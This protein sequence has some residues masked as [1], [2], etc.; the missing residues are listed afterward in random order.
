[1]GLGTWQLTIDTA[2]AIAYAL[3]LGYRLIDTSSDYGTQPGI[4][5]GFRRSGLDREQLY[6]TTKV[7]ETDDAYE[8]AQSNLKELGFDYVDL[9]LIHR[10]PSSGAGEELWEGLMMARDDG[11]TRDIGVSNY[12]ILQIERLIQVSGEVPVVNQI[13]W[14]PFGHSEEMAAYCREKG[15]RIMAYSPLTRT[16]RLSDPTLM[17]VAEQ[18]DKS[19]AQVLIRWNLQ[20]GSVPIPK[21]NMKEHQEEDLDV[22][23]FELSD[24]D[25]ERLN[26]LNEAYSSLGT[27]PYF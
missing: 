18:Y 20:R 8:R 24:T 17:L 15:I 7:E 21:A 3:G 6:L 14:S 12:S 1:M 2:D 26:S 4:G 25:M 27:L 10:P 5:E 9:L 22:F 11:L 16:K 19:P 23:D 13:E